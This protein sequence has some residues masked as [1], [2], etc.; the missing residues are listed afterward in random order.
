M[1]KQKIVFALVFAV[2]FLALTGGAEASH[3][4][5]GTVND[6]A[7]GTPADG[8]TAIIYYLGDEAN[9]VSDTI[10]TPG[11]NMYMCD[12]EIIPGHTW[13]IGDEIYAKVIDTGDGYTA[14]PV[15]KVTTGAGFDLEPDMTLQ[16]P[17]P[18]IVSD[19]QAIPPKIALNTGVSELRVTVTKT[20]F[21]IDTVTINLTPIGG[22][23]VP[24]DGSTYTWLTMYAM[25]NLSED[26]TV[27]NCT[28]NASVVGSFNLTV[29][30]TDIMGNSNTSVSIPLEV[31]NATQLDFTLIKK[32]DSTGK[33]W[34][35]IPLNTTI[36]NASSLM[37]AIGPNCDAVN[38]W[39]PYTQHSEGWIS[40]GGGMGTNFDIVPG[41]GY[42]VSVTTNTTFSILGT[43]ASI[44]SVD[45][46]KKP[47]STGKNWIGLPYDTT[48]TNASS[49][50]AAI[51][52]NCDAVNRWNPYTQQSEG[53]IS[54]GGGMGTNF[55]I[56]A[57]EGYE[58]SVTTNTT[59]TPV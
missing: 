38:R 42:E 2:A 59:W 57:G 49:L 11:T 43:I 25:T 58:A 29:N 45:L 1:T 55:N 35:S 48:I 12:A 5:T 47:D 4:I 13:T 23:W 40:M 18:P 3:W 54:M 17:S 8:H 19:P 15:S 51:G 53:W 10:G 30:A 50:M 37:A 41:E 24:M 56:V 20:Y 44:G 21:D 32:P 26:T 39:N 36:T 28:T 31:V 9:N 52:P 27:Y 7:D 33:N 14:G 6:A 22:T 46:I 34:I 16:A